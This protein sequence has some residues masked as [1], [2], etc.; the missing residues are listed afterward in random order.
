MIKPDGVQ[1]GLVGEIVRR[2]EEKGF[3]LVASVLEAFLQRTHQ[4]HVHGTCRMHGM[5]G[6]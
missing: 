3:K 4:V 2:F 1:R 5:G 6:R